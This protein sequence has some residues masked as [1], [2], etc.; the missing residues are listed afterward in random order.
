MPAQHKQQQQQQGL[1]VHPDRLS[2]A[3]LSAAAP[4]GGAGRQCQGLQTAAAAG[5]KGRRLLHHPAVAALLVLGGVAEHLGVLA[6]AVAA[7][8]GGCLA[9]VQQGQQGP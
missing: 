6:A 1:A 3:Q 9:A 2:V 4:A 7:M 8:T 5:V